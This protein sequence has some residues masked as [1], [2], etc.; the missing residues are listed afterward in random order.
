MK[1]RSFGAYLY[2]V[3]RMKSMTQKEAAELLH[4]SPQALN[5]YIQNKRYPDMETMVHI[6][7][8]FHLDA[9]RV[10]QLEKV[11]ISSALSIDEMHFI[12]MYRSLD[13]SQ[14]E[15]VLKMMKELPRK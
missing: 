13:L 5:N 12:Q 4:I 14:Q 15:F 11:D 6:L 10:F 2:H 1:E 8:V 3:I 9:N 7:K